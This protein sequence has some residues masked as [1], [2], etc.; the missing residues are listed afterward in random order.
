MSK[1]RKCIL[2]RRGGLCIYSEPGEERGVRG[3]A[4]QTHRDAAREAGGGAKGEG[5]TDKGGVCEA[6][7]EKGA[8]TP[9]EGNGDKQP[10]EQPR[11]NGGEEE[12]R[13]GQRHL[14][15]GH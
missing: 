7:A 14:R 10:E 5:I 8:G 15:Q 3:R 1:M 6:P 12:A 2:G 11:R 4:A 9:A 13:D